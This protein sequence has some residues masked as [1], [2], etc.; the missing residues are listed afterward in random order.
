MRSF[1]CVSSLKIRFR[2]LLS[3]MAFMIRR[4]K[5]LVVLNAF[6]VAGFFTFWGKCD[7]RLN[8]IPHGHTRLNGSSSDPGVSQEVLLKRLGSLEDVVYRQ[9]NGNFIPLSLSPCLCCL[10]R[11]KKLVV[12]KLTLFN[13]QQ[14]CPNL[15]GLLR[16]SEA[17]AKVAFLPH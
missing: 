11:T 3:L 13:A 2:L 1:V 4:W 9:L 17:R 14:V 8:K 7:V 5:L 10:S 6:V 12:R 15:L 16:A